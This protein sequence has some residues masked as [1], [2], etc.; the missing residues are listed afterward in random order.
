MIVRSAST[1]FS[2]SVIGW[3]TIIGTTVGASAD[4]ASCRKRTEPPTPPQS[5]HHQRTCRRRA[6]AVVGRGPLRLRGQR[7]AKN[8]LSYGWK[9][10][11][12]CSHVAEFHVGRNHARPLGRR[13]QEPLPRPGDARGVERA[14]RNE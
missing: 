6:A 1:F 12:Q 8:L 5:E 4:S 11:R 3:F 9:S 14:A 10:R 2:T 7:V 13:A